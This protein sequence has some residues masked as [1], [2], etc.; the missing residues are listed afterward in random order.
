MVINFSSDTVQKR[1]R[2]INM[3]QKNVFPFAALNCAKV[4]RNLFRIKKTQLLKYVR[5]AYQFVELANPKFKFKV[6][7]K[8]RE[9]SL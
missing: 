7:I 9:R 6:S 4:N 2:P 8:Y 5:V 3:S 1:N